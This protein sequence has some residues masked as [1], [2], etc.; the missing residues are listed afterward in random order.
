MIKFYSKIHSFSY[1]VEKR[2]P[3]SYFQEVLDLLYLEQFLVFCCPTN[4]RIIGSML[5][6]LLITAE[7]IRQS[8]IWYLNENNKTHRI[9]RKKK[10]IEMIWNDKPLFFRLPVI[11]ECIFRNQRGINFECD[12]TKRFG[13][14][15]P[16]WSIM[17]VL[18]VIFEMINHSHWNSKN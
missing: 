11:S 16:V 13:A 10:L 4:D 5:Q 2:L 3:F 7:R 12:M 9:S 17:P 1:Y 8:P 15:Y 18:L 6:I 14:C